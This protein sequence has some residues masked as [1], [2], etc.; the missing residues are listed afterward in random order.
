MF[1]LEAIVMLLMLVTLALEVD[2]PVMAM[3]VFVLLLFDD[4]L[5]P[6]LLVFPS[7]LPPP[8]LEF[9][10]AGVG[11]GDGEGDALFRLVLTGPESGTDSLVQSS[12]PADE[13]YPASQSEHFEEPRREAN[14]PD[15]HAAQV[16]FEAAPLTFELVPAGQAWQDEALPVEYV[17]GPQ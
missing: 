7:L 3:F 1:G 10:L 8:P 16:E 17:P 5:A 9:A 12:E 14:V 2:G 4:E 13:E 11:N 6:L 15:A